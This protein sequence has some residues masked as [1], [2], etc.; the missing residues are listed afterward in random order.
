MSNYIDSTQFLRLRGCTLS[1]PLG[2]VT[3]LVEA[4]L[5][6]GNWVSRV[7]WDSSLNVPCKPL[8]NALCGA[9]PGPAESRPLGG[10]HLHFD[11]TCRGFKG[12]SVCKALQEG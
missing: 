6:R 8:R 7:S 11:K 2:L 5:F 12:C 10:L 3:L 9:H 1:C 4:S